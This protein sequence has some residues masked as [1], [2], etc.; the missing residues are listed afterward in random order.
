MI[1]SARNAFISIGVLSAC[2]LTAQAFA[3]AGH[4]HIPDNG[5]FTPNQAGATFPPQP[6]SVENVQNYA[7]QPD[8]EVRTINQRSRTAVRANSIVTKNVGNERSTATTAAMADSR[9]QA[10][11]GQRFAHVATSPVKEKWGG[12]G[13]RYEVTFFSHS[14][15][16]TVKVFFEGGQLNNLTAVSAGVSQPPLAETEMIEAIDLARTHW[17]NLGN[18]RISQLTGFAI[19]TFQE[20]GSS[21][22][23]RIAYVSFHVESPQSPE[24]L[25]WVDLNSRQT[26]RA[27]VAQ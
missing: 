25:T 19:Q 3:D 5:R 24:L 23:T 27:E 22:P 10:L 13:E 15:N 14:N 16:Q 4:G 18:T 26:V 2:L 21:Y 7:P 8:N 9:V 17:M 12:D 20:D 1:K 11:L 6:R